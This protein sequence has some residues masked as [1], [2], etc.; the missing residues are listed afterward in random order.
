MKAFEELDTNETQSFPFTWDDIKDAPG[1]Y[2]PSIPLGG[3]V[4]IHREDKY[5]D[6]YGRVLRIGIKDG[7]V[8]DM[9]PA[10]SSRGRVKYRRVQGTATL[11][12]EG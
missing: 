8:C 6:G 9:T 5:I 12:F 4:I 7:L 1:I 2:L 3:T 10:P 11:T